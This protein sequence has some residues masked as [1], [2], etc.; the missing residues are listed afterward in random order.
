MFI[1]MLFNR[2]APDSLQLP[3]KSTVTVF[4]LEGIPSFLPSWKTAVGS[5]R[6]SKWG[7][8]VCNQSAEQAVWMDWSQKTNLSCHLLSFQN[9]LPGGNSSPASGWA[10]SS[11]S[12]LCPFLWLHS[13]VSHSLISAVSGQTAQCLLS[14][15]VA[16]FSGEDSVDA[17]WPQRGTL[18]C[19]LWSTCVSLLLA[20]SGETLLS[21][22][23]FFESSLSWPE[24]K[25]PLLQRNPLSEILLIFNT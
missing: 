2:Q 18:L 16:A 5:G 23:W 1:F 3:T 7:G 22:G 9:L 21:S 4:F 24:A 13:I 12:L 15:C 14:Q 19:Q 17:G 11:P 10:F 6:T 8:A 20:F 25:W